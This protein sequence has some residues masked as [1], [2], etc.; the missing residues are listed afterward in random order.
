LWGR[1]RCLNLVEVF[2]KTYRT[3]WDPSYVPDYK[4]VPKHLRD[5]WYMTILCKG[6]VVIYPYG[7]TKLAV[8]I[9]FRGPTAKKVGAIPGVTC[10]QNGDNEKTF[11]FDVSLFDQVAEIVQ[12][13]RRRRLTE[14]QRRVRIARLQA[15]QTT[16]QRQEAVRKARAAR[17]RLSRKRNPDCVGRGN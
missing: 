4:S 1:V 12:P 11:G 15:S 14:E 16:E 9:D 6:G 17:S 7:G 2:G 3:A 13:R 10:A 5:P 8:E